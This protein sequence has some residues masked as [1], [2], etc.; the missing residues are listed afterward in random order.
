MDQDM[1]HLGIQYKLHNS[2]CM[3]DP[4]NKPADENY[5]IKI[6][7][8]EI[9][10]ETSDDDMYNFKTFQDHHNLLHGSSSCHTR[11]CRVITIWL[12]G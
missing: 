3:S 11:H 8:F 2:E 7:A 9:L 5:G 6:S 1:L 4:L 10:C 12:F